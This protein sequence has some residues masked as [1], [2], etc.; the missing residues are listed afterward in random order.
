MTP[1]RQLGQ[2]QKT[3]LF[4]F[5]TKA[6]LCGDSSLQILNNIKSNQGEISSCSSLTEADSGTRYKVSSSTHCATKY[7]MAKS[8]DSLYKVKNGP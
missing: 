4:I 2:D 8:T 1:D 5:S 7:D 3:N 6:F